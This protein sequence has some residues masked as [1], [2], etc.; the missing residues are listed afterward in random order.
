MITPLIA[1]PGKINGWAGAPDIHRLIPSLFTAAVINWCSLV[2]I[3]WRERWPLAGEV[4]QKKR[5]RGATSRVRFWMS[6]QT[7]IKIGAPPGILP[8]LPHAKRGHIN[9]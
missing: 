8:A 5:R 3:H 9:S 4:G 1:M 7:P 2:S 6:Q